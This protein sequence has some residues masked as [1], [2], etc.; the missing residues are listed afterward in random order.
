MISDPSLQQIKGV[1]LALVR[2]L[3]LFRP[4]EDLNLGGDLYVDPDACM[5]STSR[6][7]LAEDSL[8]M[9]QKGANGSV[10]ARGWWTG[11]EAGNS[12][13]FSHSMNLP[14]SCFG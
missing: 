9:G 13:D 6:K 12:V 7:K 4:R 11:V 10:T 2:T 1:T 5:T 3:T 8:E 14:V